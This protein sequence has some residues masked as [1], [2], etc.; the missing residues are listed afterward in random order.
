MRLTLFDLDNTLISGD[1]DYEWA[2]YLIDL[3]VLDRSEYE[4]RNLEFYAQYKAGT[5][6]ITAFLAFALRPLAQHPLD[7]LEAWR[8]DFLQT[9]ILPLISPAARAQVAEEQARSALTAI[10][11]ATNS[12]VTAPIAAAL[13]VQHLIATEPARGADGRFTGAVAGLPSFREGKIARVHDWL[14]SLGHDWT[15]FT[16]TCFYSDSLNDLPLLQQVS[17][18]IAVDPDPTLAAHAAQAGWPVLSLRL[19]NPITN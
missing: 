3:G 17:E 19:A 16:Q 12:F 10:V 18:P 6:D 4:Q 5:L 14:Q 7:Q 11:T 2:Q 13:N 15:Q 9:R 8:Y 1:S